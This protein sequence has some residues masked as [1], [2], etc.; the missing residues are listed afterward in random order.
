MIKKFMFK[1]PTNFMGNFYKEKY[2]DQILDIFS[3]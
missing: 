1:K 3:F 2:F